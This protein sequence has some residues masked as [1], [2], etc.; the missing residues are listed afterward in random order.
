MTFFDKPL[1]R[2]TILKGGA[3]AIATLAA[4]GVLRAAEPAPIKVGILQPVTG[5]LASGIVLLS[6]AGYFVPEM[7]DWLAMIPGK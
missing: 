4:P 5:A 3:A 6:A 7:H 2:R 1:G